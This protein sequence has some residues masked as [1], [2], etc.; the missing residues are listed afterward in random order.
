MKTRART[1]TRRRRTRSSRSRALQAARRKRRPAKCVRAR[2]LSSA[3]PNVLNRACRPSRKEV[4]VKH[5]TISVTALASAVLV[6]ACATT[7][8]RVEQLDQARADVEALAADPLVQQAAS[9]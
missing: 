5:S 8:K 7:P 2:T 4:V 1:P 3:K 6:A 9:E